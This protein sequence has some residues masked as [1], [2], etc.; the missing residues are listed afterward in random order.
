MSHRVLVVS[1]HPDDEV[2][3]CGGTVANLAQQ[4]HEIYTL[5]LG[6]GIAARHGK[7]KAKKIK[8]LCKLLRKQLFSANK[9]IGVRKV[10]PYSFPDNEFDTVSLLDIVK[11]I[12]K[13]KNDIKPD[14]VFTHYEK[15]LNIDHRITYKAVLTATRPMPRETVKEI[16]SFEVL[17]STEWNF[18]NRFSPDVFFDIGNTIKLK[19]QAM[20]T[21]KSEL[22]KFPHP[23][24]VEG[25]KMIAKVWGMKVG[26]EYA[27]AFK[28]VRIIR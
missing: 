24:S 22:R 13:I 10:F 6:T 11:V 15:D 23:R 27:E 4:K 20:K 16:Y 17:S 21:Y 26:L 9:I 25:I 3:G 1:A 14:I 8:Y 7:D 12:E 18:P 19:M 2:L 28:T 5:I